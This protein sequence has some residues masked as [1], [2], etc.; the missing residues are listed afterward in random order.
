MAFEILRD[1]L[2]GDD[3]RQ[4]LFDA[5]SLS[6]RLTT[7]K[8]FRNEPIR[9]NGKGA[10]RYYSDLREI[11]NE[12]DSDAVDEQISN[13]D[14]L[15]KAV[16][17]VVRTRGIRRIKKAKKQSS[18]VMREVNKMWKRGLYG[19]DRD[20]Y[21][22]IVLL[23]RAYRETFVTVRTKLRTELYAC[24]P[25]D[26]SIS[27]STRREIV[28]NLYDFD[29]SKDAYVLNKNLIPSSRDI[30]ELQ[31]LIAPYVFEA[32]KTNKSKKHRK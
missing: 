3:L 18:R 31:L 14:D 9:I 6:Y 2:A 23:H 17:S 26:L 16:K 28:K 5:Q 19:E 15:T 29:S 10:N 30:R 32:I 20:I 25:D 13:N 11:F 4:A 12:W 22:A 21:D 7:M 24:I 1:T 27:L 8:T